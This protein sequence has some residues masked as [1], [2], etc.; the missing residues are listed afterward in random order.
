MVA[1][2]PE[3]VTAEADAFTAA[4]HLRLSVELELDELPEDYTRD[5]IIAELDA[6]MESIH[7][8]LADSYTAILFNVET[9]MRQRA[10]HAIH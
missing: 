5:D 9:A 2:T 1:G 6:C 8:T 3:E 7:A 4:L 10:G